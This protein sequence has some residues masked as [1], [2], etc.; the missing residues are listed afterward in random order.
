[1][2][3]SPIIKVKQELLQRYSSEGRIEDAERIFAKEFNDPIFSAV[4]FHPEEEPS[5][6]E[7]NKLLEEM[8]MDIQGIGE[9]LT[10]SASKLSNL[11]VSSK[12]RIEEVDNAIALEEERLHD[13]NMLCGSDSSF[14]S[15]RLLTEEDFSG[16]ASYKEGAFQ[17]GVTREA[18]VALDV[19]KVEGNGFEGNEYV[20]KNSGFLI[21]FMNTGNRRFLTDDLSSTVFEYSRLNASP[22]EKNQFAMLNYDGKEAECT[23]TL[24]S[25]RSVSSMNV[26]SYDED[27]EL[28]FLSVSNDNITYREVIT[29][30][31]KFNNKR[32]QYSFSERYIFGT[33]TLAFPNSKFIKVGFKSNGHTEDEIAFVRITSEKGGLTNEPEEDSLRDIQ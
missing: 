25:S 20:L 23:I 22:K 29:G 8:A 16:T 5:L 13:M 4:E 11:I 33:G 3:R 21:D 24:S 2:D 26:E 28:T 19:I 12:A 18:R 15:V 10:L 7:I 14:G 6:K 31:L 9:E 30:P 17:A 32:N 27:L 1:M